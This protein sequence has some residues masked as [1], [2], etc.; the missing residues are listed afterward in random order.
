MI[1]NSFSYE[2]QGEALDKEREK[3][4]KMIRN[5]ELS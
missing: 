1:N 2:F 4:L 3:P 5:D